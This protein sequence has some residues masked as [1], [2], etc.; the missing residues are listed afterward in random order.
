MVRPLGLAR[1]SIAVTARLSLGCGGEHAGASPPVLRPIDVNGAG[2]RLPS[3]FH[4]GLWPLGPC[5]RSERG[6]AC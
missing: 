6:G 1:F 2:S 5:V 4:E 3:A